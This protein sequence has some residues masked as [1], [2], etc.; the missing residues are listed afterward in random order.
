M[1]RQCAPWFARPSATSAPP[2][3]HH[4]S[5]RRRIQRSP[6]C[7]VNDLAASTYAIGGTDAPSD[8]PGA[9]TS[10]LTWAPKADERDRIDFV[11]YH[12]DRRLRL[13][14]SVI[15]GPSTSI[16]RNERVAESGRDKF[17]EPNWTWPTDHKAI[18]TTFRV[19]TRH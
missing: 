12:P 6:R 3:H 10:Q 15:V 13:L 11:F 19:S 14:D 7:A 17:W 1:N 2:R 4:P 5:I 8:N 18:L 9:E 16:A